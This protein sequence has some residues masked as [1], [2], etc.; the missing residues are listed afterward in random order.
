MRLTALAP[1]LLLAA[2]A[3]SSGVLK[4]GP[5]TY[6]LSVGAAPLRG[7]YIGAKQI[8]LDEA[9]KYCA[10]GGKEI[11]VTNIS[12]GTVNRAGAGT[13]D[14]TFRCLLAGDRDLQ[15]PDYQ[16]PPTTVIQDQ[17]SK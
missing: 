13:V 6:T 15:R 14:L 11:L 2:C 4:M 10:A 9:G 7:G 1:C 17:R 8:G 16:A 5:D 3:T 12:S